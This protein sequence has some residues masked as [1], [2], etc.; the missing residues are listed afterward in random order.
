MAPTEASLLATYLLSRAQLRDFLTPQQFTELFPRS[1]RSHPH[2]SVLYRE[3]Q[4]QRALVADEVER[5]IA[6]EV[7]RGERQRREVVNARRRAE[8][9]RTGLD[10]SKEDAREMQMEIEVCLLVSH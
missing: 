4:H 2:V 7:K 5:N 10:Q 3:L 9:G 1:Q 6:I 8:Q